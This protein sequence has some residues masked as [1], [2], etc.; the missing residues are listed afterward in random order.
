MYPRISVTQMVRKVGGGQ[1]H[2]VPSCVAAEGGDRCRPPGAQARPLAG[3]RL[4]GRVQSPSG[5]THLD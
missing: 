2:L 3:R 4:S 5:T 1:T